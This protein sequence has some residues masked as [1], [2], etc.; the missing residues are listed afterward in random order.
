M[1]S[2]TISMVYAYI[3]GKVGG[4]GLSVGPGIAMVFYEMEDIF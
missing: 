3:G 1:H 4:G 2:C